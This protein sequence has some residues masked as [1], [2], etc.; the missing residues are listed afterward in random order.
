V[1][2][3]VSN[4]RVR[5]FLMAFKSI[6]ELGT[7]QLQR[8]KSSLN[9]DHRERSPPESA[10]CHGSGRHGAERHGI[11]AIDGLEFQLPHSPC[12]NIQSPPFQFLSAQLRILPRRRLRRFQRRI[13]LPQRPDA[14]NARDSPRSNF[15][16][17]SVVFIPSRPIQ[18]P[19]YQEGGASRLIYSP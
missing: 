9:S 5:P 2:S 17:G 4:F 1:Q 12:R 8:I 18:F 19:K 14:P 16:L 3:K 15:S 6:C 11:L 10:W 13:R 7:P